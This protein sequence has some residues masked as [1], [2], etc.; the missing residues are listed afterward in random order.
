M[1][2]LYEITFGAAAMAAAS[3]AQPASAQANSARPACTADTAEATTIADIITAGPA[4]MGRCVSVEGLAIGSQLHADN[5]ARYR[6]RRA[7][8]DP[9]STGAIIGLYR[10]NL[11]GD[12]T[13]RARIVGR[14]E[15]CAALLAAAQAASG[16]NDIVMM[17]G[18]C[19]YFSGPVVTA[20]SVTALSDANQ[21]RIARGGA[22]PALGDIAPMAA[23][24]PRD[25][26]LLAANMLF[27]SLGAREV[28][29]T[30]LR[31]R[32]GTTRPDAEIFSMM[33]RLAAG[34][35]TR[36]ASGVTEIF[37]WRAPSYASAE[38]RRGF[39]QQAAQITE[40]IA[41]H[42]T[43]PDAA[44]LWP[45]SEGDA[46]L[47]GQRPYGCVRISIGADDATTYEMGGTADEDYDI[48]EP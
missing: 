47:G 31:P 46:M 32:G 23:G 20:T 25:R 36:A 11:G 42:S 10:G 27:A 3:L 5:L 13:A 21:V 40:G 2:H 26:L 24:A 22:D 48:R 41:C 44:A 9:S 7:Y 43:R 45:I 6:Q 17:G 4:A 37:G 35:G 15:N 1:R 16:P 28:A 29:L 14:V 8:G 34:A 19:H 18:Y 39:A 33:D 12:Q 38:E 30:L